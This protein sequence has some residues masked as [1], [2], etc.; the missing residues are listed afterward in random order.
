MGIATTSSSCS[1]ADSITS[2]LIGATTVIA[3]STSSSISDS[4]II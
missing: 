2:F 3:F 4:K 1:S